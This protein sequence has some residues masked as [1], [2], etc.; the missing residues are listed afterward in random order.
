MKNDT[1]IYD[2]DGE[3]IRKAGDNHKWTAEEAQKRI[4]YYQDKIKAINEA[5]NKTESD[6]KKI[7]IYENY[8]ANLTKYVW[9]IVNQ[10]SS[11]ELNKIFAQN[12]TE[13]QVNKALEE[14]KNDISTEGSTTDNV[15]GPN[16]DNN[17]SDTNEELGNDEIIR[18]EN[19]D[20][21]EERPV[22]QGDLLVERGDVNTVMDEYVD[23]VEE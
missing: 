20:I 17:K 2:I 10:L 12:T 1:N 3:L 15:Q 11:E 4:K 19:C 18:R 23:F 21:H 5:E 14:L 16:A 6:L 13:E 8:C 7:K 22:S 9:N